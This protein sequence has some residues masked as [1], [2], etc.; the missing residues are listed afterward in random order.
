MRELDE[1]SPYCL[2]SAVKEAHYL[3]HLSSD[4]LFCIPKPGISLN[5]MPETENM[6]I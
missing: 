4:Y 5:Y 1:R 2:L 6:L 3:K